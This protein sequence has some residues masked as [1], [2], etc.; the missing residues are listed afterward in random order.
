MPYVAEIVGLINS[1]L[2]A[3]KLNDGTRFVKNINGI[4]ELVVRNSEDQ[5]T[6]PVL[7]NTSDYKQYDG[8]DD[9]YSIQ[10]YHRVLDIEQV[11]S[12]LSYGDGATNGREQAKMRLVCFADRKRTKLDPYQLAFLLRSSLNQ[13]FLGTTLTPYAGLLGATIEAQQD[14]Y[15][16]L[17]VW[18]NE[19][20]LP[21]ESYPVKLHQMLLSVDYNI[22]TDY[23][24]SC[25]AS[26]LEC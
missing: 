9:R 19:Y 23:N 5:T 10:I 1:S 11:E 21:V 26:C 8:I 25:I 15:N 20:A 17:E 24:N 16:G 4:S 18:Q 13:Q 3:N 14:N 22:I 7:V 12:P 2:E 6:I